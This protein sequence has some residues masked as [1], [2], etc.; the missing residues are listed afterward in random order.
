MKCSKLLFILVLSISLLQAYSQDTTE[1]KDKIGRSPGDTV[2]I[3]QINN[4]H[5]IMTGQELADA[6]FPKSW[7]LFGSKA[8]MSF[9]GYVKI[10][11]I[12]DFNGVHNDRFELSTANV[13]VPNSGVI[14]EE[15]YMNLF[16]RESRFNF[17]FRTTTSKGKPMRFYLEMDFWNLDRDPFHNVPRLRH[18]YVVYNRWLLGRTWGLLTDV[19]SIPIT[20][21]FQAGDAINGSRRAQI[22]YETEIGNKKVKIAAALEM[23]EF[24]DI[25]PNGFDGQASMLLPMLSARVTKEYASGSRLFFGGS[26]YQLRWDGLTTGPNA[27]A[28]GWG[29]IFSGITNFTK[30]FN[31]RWNATGGDGWSNNVFALLGTENSAI[32]TPNGQM[33]TQYMWSVTG[34]LSYSFSSRLM[35]NLSGGWVELYPSQYKDINDY[36]SGAIGHINLIYSPFKNV[37]VGIEYQIAQRVNIN[38][39]SG[40]ANRIQISGKYVF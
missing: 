5:P 33:Q 11:Y 10:D 1:K 25:D 6:S 7:P 8:R 23:L 28:I 22:R 27:T 19:Y 3:S 12:Q 9:G 4:N 39:Y 13:H 21:D 36:N 38:G 31:F 37:N 29:F 18:I 17:D 30:K 32:L 15:G 40:L 2:R 14:K 34:A 16:A 20:L 24:P 26:I 35:S